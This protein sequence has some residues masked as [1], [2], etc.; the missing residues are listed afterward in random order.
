L[1]KVLLII[2]NESFTRSIL[3]WY[4]VLLKQKEWEPIIFSTVGNHL[5][6][7]SLQMGLSVSATFPPDGIG[8]QIPGDQTASNQTIVERSW[9]NRI[10]SFL[11]SSVIKSCQSF[12]WVVRLIQRMLDLRRQLLFIRGLIRREKINVMIICQSSPDC[13]A[14]IYIWAARRESIPVVVAPN[15]RWSERTYADTY[16]TDLSLSLDRC[17][18]SIVAKIYPRWVTAYNGLQMIRIQPEI[19]LAQ[20]WLGLGSPQPWQVVGAW[21]EPVVVANQ[22]VSDFYTQEGVK[23]E[24]VRVVG[25]PEHDIM[26]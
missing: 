9:K 18:N 11:P 23:E 4:K 12:I 22:V 3:R 5:T 1:K 17:I 20:E 19:V 16:K 15:C 10:K 26:A 6:Q 24:Q 25:S 13:D 8:W 2:N 7:E 21:N 14:P